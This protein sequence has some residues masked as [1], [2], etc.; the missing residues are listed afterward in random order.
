MIKRLSCFLSTALMLFT[1]E[2][3][4]A[5]IDTAAL[6]ILDNMSLVLGDLN[7]VG[8][9]SNVS[10]DIAFSNDLNIKQF[11]KNNIKIAGPNKFISRFFGE[12]R[13][14]IYKYNGEQV[15]FYSLDNNR[16]AIAD[17]PDNLIETMDWLYTEFG[18][19]FTTADI[20]YPSFS[21]DL[22]EN[23][24]YM[25]FIG[26]VNLNGKQVFHIVASNE[27]I[28]VQFWISNDIYL[29]PEKILLTYL[30]QPFSPQYEV[31]FSDWEINMV[32][33]ASIF[34]FDP[35]PSSEQITWMSRN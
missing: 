30:D 6:T 31:Q 25:Q 9:T 8:F 19:E 5:K 17:A 22:A 20:F 15:F 2:A 27:T 14:E 34:E 29:L 28:S 24:D 35:P 32:Y 12:K 26:L 11:S 33:P 3:Q 23:M 18:I 7:S 21:Q 4:E 1:A 13:S 10:R 16:Y